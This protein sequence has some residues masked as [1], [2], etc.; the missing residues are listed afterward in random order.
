MPKIVIVTDDY[1]EEIDEEF[2]A[3]LRVAARERPDDLWDLLDHI[4][5]DAD[6]EYEVYLQEDDGST[7]KLI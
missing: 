2:A 7:L 1:T 6:P 4:T 3:E 5:S